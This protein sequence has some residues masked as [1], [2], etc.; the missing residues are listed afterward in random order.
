[1]VLYN[2]SY[3][4]F[5]DKSAKYI[6]HYMYY[7]F[8]FFLFTQTYDQYVHKIVVLGKFPEFLVVSL[9]RGFVFSTKKK[10]KTYL[11]E[12]AP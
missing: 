9:S 7:I 5:S 3:K 12:D 10:T 8:F 4:Y 6:H 11:C 2:L 1:M